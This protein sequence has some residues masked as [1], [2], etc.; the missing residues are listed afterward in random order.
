M[1]CGTT[2][3]VNGHYSGFA[4]VDLRPRVHGNITRQEGSIVELVAQALASDVRIDGSD[5]A[6][7]YSV[8]SARPAVVHFVDAHL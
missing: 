8:R 6:M 4:E 2:C 1:A 3:V 5:W 7:Q